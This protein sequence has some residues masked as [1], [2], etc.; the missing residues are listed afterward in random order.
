M[1]TGLP[2][3][4]QSG[5]NPAN[6]KYRGRE[7][8]GFGIYIHW[9]FCHKK[10]PYCDFNS[11][12]RDQIDQSGFG[13]AII[14]ELKTMADISGFHGRP[15]DS[16]FF[17]GGTPSLMEAEIAGN[18]LNTITTLFSVSEQCEIT[19]EA[20]PTVLE[21]DR[22]KAFHDQGIN[23]LSLGIQSLK[24]EQLAFL[25][26]QHSAAE[27]R[28][29][30]TKAQQIFDRVSADFIY[31]LP[32]Q[33]LDDWKQ[34]LS[35]ILDLGCD[36]LS[37]YQLTLEQ[38]TAFYSLAKRGRLTMLDETMALDQFLLTQEM[39]QSRGLPAYEVSNHAAPGQE[40]QHNLIYWR[41]GDWLGAGP[42][43]IGRFWHP[44]KDQ[45]SGQRMETRARKDPDGW[46]EDV[47]KHGHGL[48]HQHGEDA[49][50]FAS[51]AVMMG[52]R[53]REGIRLDMIERFAGRRSDWLDED[54]VTHLCKQGLLSFHDDHLTLTDNG[55]TVMNTVIGR[56]LR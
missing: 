55:K 3:K 52:L 19:L 39:C 28:A 27:A 54:E 32:D 21:A 30:L 25:G 38:G 15:L 43:A 11:H 33:Q 34:Q 7:A 16:V 49:A 17:G 40:S 42:G 36:H 20:N 22:L 50:S 4:T 1:M 23:R 5:A 47:N 2:A 14:T 46:R 10:C 48:S 35:Q 41:G 8:S 56:I 24:D 9:P 6:G 31:A 44:P 12:V 37:L 45:H 13:N 29:A 53:L 18:I 26:R 51:E